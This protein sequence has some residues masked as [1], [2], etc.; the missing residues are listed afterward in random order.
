MA[1]NVFENPGRSLE[2]G[3][4]FG[5]AFAIRSSKTALSSLPEV[6]HFTTLETGF[7]MEFLF[8]FIP[9]KWNKKTDRFCPSALLENKND[10]LE[11]RKEK[12]LSDS[13]KNSIEEIKK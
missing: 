10:D 2:T 9:P 6:I 11:Q 3:A 13:F 7:A 5:T 4:N 1:K 12:Q 8:D